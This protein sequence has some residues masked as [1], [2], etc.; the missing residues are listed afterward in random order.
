ME[1]HRDLSGALFSALWPGLGQLAQGRLL[2]GVG[3]LVWTT[4]GVIGAA[5]LL[6]QDRSP[7]PVVTEVSLVALWSIIDAYRRPIAKLEQAI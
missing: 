4:L 3:F 5:W 6:T 2:V 1:Y 7:V